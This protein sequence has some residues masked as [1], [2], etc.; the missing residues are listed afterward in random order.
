VGFRQFVSYPHS[1][2]PLGKTY[3]VVFSY[4]RSILLEKSHTSSPYE[5]SKETTDVVANNSMRWPR[6]WCN[7]YRGSHHG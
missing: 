3:M 4:T 2:P 1:Y 6:R 5:E 7:G